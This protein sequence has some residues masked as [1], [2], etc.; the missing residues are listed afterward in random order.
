[1]LAARD[2]VLNF[3]ADTTPSAKIPADQP[4]AVVIKSRR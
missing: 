3:A 2:P 4:T 1:M